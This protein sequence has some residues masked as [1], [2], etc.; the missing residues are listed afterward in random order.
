MFIVTAVFAAILPAAY[1]QEMVM[2]VLILQEVGGFTSLRSMK[3]PFLNISALNVNKKIY[4]LHFYVTRFILFR[5][6]NHTFDIAT[7]CS[8]CPPYSKHL[9]ICKYFAELEQQILL[10]QSMNT[11]LSEEFRHKIFDK[12]LNY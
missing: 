2:S 1:L 7:W 12:R 10:F 3:K 5:R 8:L 6:Y 4:A 11:P 9:T